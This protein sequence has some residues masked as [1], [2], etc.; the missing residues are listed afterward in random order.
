MTRRVEHLD[1]RPCSRFAVAGARLV[2]GRPQAEREPERNEVER[3]L[4]A[5]LDEPPPAA[6]PYAGAAGSECGAAVV[7]CSSRT[8]VQMCAK[9]PGLRSRHGGDGQHRAKPGSEVRVDGLDADS[10][11]AA[12]L[13]CMGGYERSSCRGGGRSSAYDERRREQGGIVLQRAD[14]VRVSYHKKLMRNGWPVLSVGAKSYQLRR[15]SFAA[16]QRWLAQQRNTPVCWGNIGERAY[17]MFQDRFYW[18]NDRLNPRQVHAVLA[19]R[20][21]RDAGRI[22]RAEARLAAGGGAHPPG[23]GVIPD[24]VKHFVFSRDQGRCRHCGSN[25]EL[26][27]DHI[28]PVSLGGA[29]SAEN[30]QILCGPCNRRKADG[31]TVQ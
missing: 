3:R 29:S 11:A 26:Q 7:D 28:I 30:L 2:K 15:M 25:V 23:R 14:N 18:D 31:L 5:T 19:D 9:D 13:D 21:S 24:D 22:Q 10:A 12:R 27:F 20:H 1:A 8:G 16:Y 4:A 6:A 17:W